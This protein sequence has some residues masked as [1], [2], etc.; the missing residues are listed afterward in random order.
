MNIHEYQA[1]TLLGKF[2]V[3][4]PRGAVAYTAN[5]AEKAANIKIIDYRMIGATGR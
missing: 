5:E 4:V 1:K 3:S 2:G